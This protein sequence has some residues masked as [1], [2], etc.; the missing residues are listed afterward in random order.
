VRNGAVI[1]PDGST[2]VPSPGTLV[3]LGAGLLGV[4]TTAL[5]KR[6]TK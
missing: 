5:L 2:G 1:P 6:R 4:G 3:L